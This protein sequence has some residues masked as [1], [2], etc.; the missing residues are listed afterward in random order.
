MEIEMKPL[1]VFRLGGRNVMQCRVMRGRPQDALN[2]TLLYCDGERRVA[3]KLTG[4]STAWNQ[5]G[6]YDFTFD[7]PLEPATTLSPR[8]VVVADD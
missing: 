1:S 5:D 7:G 2:R 6:V 3:L 8:A 4:M